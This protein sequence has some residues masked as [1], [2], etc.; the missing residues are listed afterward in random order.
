MTTAEEINARAEL[1]EQSDTAEDVIAEA[2]WFIAVLAG[3]YETKVNACEAILTRK[4][5]LTRLVTY[6]VLVSSE[7]LWEIL[8]DQFQLGEDGDLPLLSEVTIV[9][10]DG[11]SVL[12]LSQQFTTLVS[13]AFDDRAAEY[14]AKLLPTH[15]MGIIGAFAA[16]IDNVDSDE[17]IDEI[18]GEITGFFIQ[19]IR[20]THALLEVYAAFSD[21]E[22]EPKEIEPSE[23]TDLEL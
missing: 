22:Q 21:T 17:A 5:A 7:V 20:Q 13:V 16:R 14:R 19:V 6:A 4:T 1:L 12:E 15:I 18:A 2:K 11:E 8:G 23:I 3:D 9:G 10:S